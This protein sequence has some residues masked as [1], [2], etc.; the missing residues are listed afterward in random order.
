LSEKHRNSPVA[1]FTY[2]RPWHTRQT[3]EALLKNAEAAG[4]D[5]I[6][7]SDGAKDEASGE[8]VGDVRQYLRTIESF[9]SVRIVERKENLGL[10]KSIISG[11]TEVVNEH[12]RVIVLEDDLVTSPYFLKYM[13][14]AL[15]AYQDDDRVISIHGYCYP[16]EG[17]PETFFLKGADCWGWATWKRGWDLFEPDGAKLLEELTQR[18]LLHRFDYFGVFDYS[19]MLKGQIEGRNDSWAVRWY[20]SALLQDQLTLYPGKSLVHNTGNDASGRHCAAGEAFDVDLSLSPVQVGDIAVEEDQ[21][22]LMAVSRFLK[23]VKPSFSARARN[24][25]KRIVRGLASR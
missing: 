7:F 10:A 3:V 11:V 23:Q 24:K 17:L 19:G 22:A 12:G 25:A 20:A 18:N 1:L 2:N 5:L 13:N 16:I 6:V 14:D 21:D 9:K 15:D 4:S 8:K